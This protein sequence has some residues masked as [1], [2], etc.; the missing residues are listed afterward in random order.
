MICAMT[1]EEALEEAE[2]RWP[3]DGAIRHWV[4]QRDVPTKECLVG[5][6]IRGVFRVLGQGETWEEAFK[7]AE[8]ATLTR[9]SF[10]AMRWDFLFDPRLPL[11]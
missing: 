9:N 11:D 2:R 1:D 7:E 10:H 6:R 5:R 8:R 3:E 4:P